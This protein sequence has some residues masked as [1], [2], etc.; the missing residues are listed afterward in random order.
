MEH[1]E[2]WYHQR[3]DLSVVQKHRLTGLLVVAAQ[4]L[5]DEGLVLAKQL[6]VQTD[7]A[8][9]VDA[10]DITAELSAPGRFGAGKVVVVT[11]SRQR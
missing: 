1:E 11:R 5:G 2:D 3:T 6:G 8:G 7:V 4:L 9:G 10:V